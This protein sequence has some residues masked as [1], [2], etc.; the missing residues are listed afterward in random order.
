EAAVDDEIGPAAI[1]RWHEFLDGGIDRGV[2]TADA[3]AGEETKY[4]KTQHVPRQRGRGGRNE[5]NRERDEEQPLAPEP[6]GEPA[7]AERSQHRAGQ[8]GAAGESHI[9]V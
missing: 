2:F 7:E 1:A 6:I 4:R 5:I 8:I 9:A 3:R